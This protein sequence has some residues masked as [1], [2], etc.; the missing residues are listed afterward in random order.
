[1]MDEEFDFDAH[2]LLNAA[3]KIEAEITGLDIEE[4]QASLRLQKIVINSKLKDFK[5]EDKPKLL[6]LLDIIYKQLG[7]AGDWK[8]FYKVE[9]AL[10]SQVL[11]L[12]KGIPISLGILLLDILDSCSFKAQGICFPSGFMI[13]IHID[14]ERLYLDPFTGELLNRNKLELKVRGE[15]GNHARL[16]SNMLKH[17]SNE[18]II[19]RYIHVLKAAYVQAE[20][21]ELALICTEIILRLGP[22][23]AYEVRDRGFL[24]QQLNCLSLACDDF[25]FFIK[26]HPQDPLVTILKKQ[27]QSMSFKPQVIH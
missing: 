26:K 12:R 10:L 2:S 8:A 27:I 21:I 9:N 25:E 20:S 16:H 24:F 7:F 5:Q 11:K 22:D 19:K 13:V 4:F 15:L 6:F 17:D 18:S 3:L 14:D 1:M 23:D